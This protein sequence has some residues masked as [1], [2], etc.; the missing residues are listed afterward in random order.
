MKKP[1]T[2]SWKK[3]LDR[4]VSEYIRIVEP[5]CVICG[6]ASQ[7]TNGHLFSR[8]HNSLRWDIRPDGNCH[9][10]CWPCNFKHVRDTVPYFK[11][12][13]NK[14]GQE[15]FDELYQEWQ[16]INQMK[17]N[18]VIDMVELMKV[19]LKQLKEEI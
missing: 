16:G 13:I 9:T 19:K 3:K 1:T 15:R 10:Q 17:D 2:S 8:R 18:D 11:W 5:N 12:Y 14:F 7:P 4:L 6:S